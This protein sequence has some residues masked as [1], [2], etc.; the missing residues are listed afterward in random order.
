MTSIPRD[1]WPDVTL[2]LLADPYRY[3]QRRAGRLGTDTFRSRLL[4]QPTIFLTGPEAAAFF[5]EPGRFHRQKAIPELVAHVLFGEGGVQRL[6]GE[7]HRHR[8]AQWRDLLAGGALDDLESVTERMWDDA[9]PELEAM[10]SMDVFPQT[11]RVLTASVCRWAGV[12]LARHLIGGI[13]DML[14]SLFLHA[15]SVGPEHLKGRQNR[16]AATE[17]AQRLVQGA[18]SA[19]AAGRM[20]KVARIARWSADDGAPLPEAA[21]ATEVLNLLRPTVAVAVYLAFLAMALHRHPENRVRVAEDAAFRRAF[22]QEVRRTYPFFPAVAARTTGPTEW[23]G[24]EV[25]T[26]TRAVLDLYGTSRHPLAWDRPE[27]F[28][29]ERFLD[30][31]GDQWS[32]VPQGGGDAAVTHRCPGED[33]TIRLMCLFAREFARARYEVTTPEAEP[34][35]RA[36][37]ALPKGGFQLSGFRAG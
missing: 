12:P 30:W 5:Y 36:A 14:S 28:R 10:S 31:P 2:P 13:T 29:P 21:A 35:Y 8:K 37:P 32:L 20:D 27:E 3:I 4:G 34:N 23:R 11:A 18:R 22:V 24:E 33:A 1:A 9:L 6:D 17:W 7:P 26:D 19:E 25:A 16:K 15:G